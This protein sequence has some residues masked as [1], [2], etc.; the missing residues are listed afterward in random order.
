MRRA[1]VGRISALLLASAT[2]AGCSS[3]PVIPDLPPQ[4]SAATRAPLWTLRLDGGKLPSFLV[5]AVLDDAVYAASTGG[6]LMRVDAG[7][8]REVWRIDLDVE[9]S[10]AVG[11]GSGLVVLG[12]KAGEVIAVDAAG[13]LRWRV[14]ATS[15][16]QGAPLVHDDLVVVATRDAR[17]VGLDA[18]RG[19]RRWI[20]QRS[21]PPLVLRGHTGMAAAGQTIYAGLSGG[22]LT[23]LATVNGN[24]RWESAVSNPRGTTEI[25]RISDVMGTPWVGRDEVCAVSYQGRVGCFLLGNGTSLW[26]RDL[27]SAA[28]LSGDAR[29]LLVTDERSNVVALDRADGSIVWRQTAFA[30]RRMSGPLA[31]GRE[32]AVGDVQGYVHFLARDSGAVVARAEVGGDPIDVPPVRMS[33]GMIVQTRGGRLAAFAVTE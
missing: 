10:G 33:G 2:V 18:A 13:K 11:A 4:G 1:L 28:G 25:E 24:A 14:R 8:G 31:L 32:V 20:Y 16:V 29:L 3:G 19:D 22:R 12:T 26:G 30:G 23:A 5:P 7:S 17:I 15:E 9:L 21:A 27:S 6:V